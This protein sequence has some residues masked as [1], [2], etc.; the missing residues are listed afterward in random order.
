MITGTSTTISGVTDYTDTT[1]TTTS[2]DDAI[3][4]DT[5]MT[6][7][8]AQ[9]QNQDPLNPM[10]ATQ[11]STQLAQ[12]SSLEQLYNINE[13][14]ETLIDSQSSSN[15]YQVLDLI[16]KEIEADG[17]ILSLGDA[18]TATGGFTIESDADC[19]V[20]IYNESGKAIK[21]IDLGS[22]EAGD[23]TFEWDGNEQDG[24]DAGAGLYS[25]KITAEDAS[26]KS[27]TAETVIKGI[28]DRVNMDGDE[29]TLYVGSLSLTLS[30]IT[31]ITLAAD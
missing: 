2:T 25:F 10:D 6:L 9:L 16:G 31:D 24:D 4:K 28:V 23:H 5:F 30:D 17:D 13:N 1:A 12:F 8:L 29:P 3:G 15:T 27:V 20:V 22:L 7:L 21:T 18:G 11:F 14:M 26:G 19:S